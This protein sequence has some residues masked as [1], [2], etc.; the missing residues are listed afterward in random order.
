M[1]QYQK[2]LQTEPAQWQLLCKEKILDCLTLAKITWCIQYTRHAQVRIGTILKLPRKVW[3][4]ALH[5]QSLDCLSVHPQTTTTNAVHMYIFYW[6]VYAYWRMMH[7]E[8]FKKW[9]QETF[10]SRKVPKQD[11]LS[12]TISPLY[13]SF[14]S[15]FSEV[16]CAQYILDQRIT[17]LQYDDNVMRPIW[18]LPFIHMLRTSLGIIRGLHDQSEDCANNLRIVAKCLHLSFAEDNLK[19]V[20]IWTLLI[21]YTSYI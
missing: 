6:L 10:L 8:V 20:L 2:F 7:R 18:G 14:M 21:T 1:L 19:I 17:C 11:W 12:I 15:T 5:G 3:I 16:S 13:Y 4:W 9:T